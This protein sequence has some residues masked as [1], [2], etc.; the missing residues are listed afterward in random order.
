MRVKRALNTEHVVV[1]VKPA[2]K[3]L[4]AS[5]AADQVESISATARR[6]I[7]AGMQSR[8][9]PAGAGANG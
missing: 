9:Q 3:R 8:S 5:I 7:L 6:F 2:E 4:L 1:R